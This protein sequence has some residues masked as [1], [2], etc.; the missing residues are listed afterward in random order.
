MLVA[1]TSLF[2]S[3][4]HPL[5]HVDLVRKGQLQDGQWIF[6]KITVTVYPQLWSMW[7][8]VQGLCVFNKVAIILMM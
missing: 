1:I 7:A 4:N 8:T 5:M 2:T 6:R 3:P